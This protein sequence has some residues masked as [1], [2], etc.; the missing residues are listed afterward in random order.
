MTRERFLSRKV[1]H[2]RLYS[3]LLVVLGLSTALTIPL[4]LFVY[5]LRVRQGL[6]VFVWHIPDWV[7]PW[8]AAICSAYL[9]LILMTAWLRRVEPA[10]GR[11]ASRVLNYLL[12]PALPFGTALGIYGLVK[13][14]RRRD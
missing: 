12:L 9:T 7:G 1:D 5:F 14:D 11:R 2:G 3:V 8:N 13:V 4:G 6:P 10:A